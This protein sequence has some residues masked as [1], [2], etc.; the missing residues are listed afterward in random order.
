M[1]ERRERVKKGRGKKRGKSEGRMRVK[2]GKGKKGKE[3][4]KGKGKK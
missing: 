2:K 3:W 4:K 1:S